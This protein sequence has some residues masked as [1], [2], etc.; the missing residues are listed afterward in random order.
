MESKPF[1]CSAQQRSAKRRK[2]TILCSTIVADPSFAAA[3]QPYPR[4]K[5]GLLITCPTQL[6]SAQ[7]FFSANLNGGPATHCLTVPP[8][9]SR[10]TTQ[11]ING[12]VC[13]DFGLCAT[14][15]NPSTRQAIT[16]PLVCSKTSKAASSTYYC[17]NSLGF[18]PVSKQYK[19]LNSWRNY[20]TGKTEY[21]VFSLGTQ[22]WRL[23]P[24]GPPY[25]PRRESICV[26]GIIYFRTLAD[27]VAFDVQNE[28]FRVIQLPSDAP[29]DVNT[30]CL[31]QLA[32]RLAIVNFQLDSQ[33]QLSL[34]ILEDYW[35]EIWIL[36]HIV[37]PTYWRKKNQNYLVAGTIATGEILLAP[38]FLSNPFYVFYYDLERSSLR[39]VKI[40]GL[41]E[42]DSLDVSRNAVTVTGYEE[43]IL[44][45]G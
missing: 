12:I 29:N 22:S 35:N 9:Y 21:R 7:T 36:H 31:I 3:H 5:P 20:Q 11:S 38:C 15:C 16:L 18:D 30:S 43:N 34:W 13:M 44:S 42:Y 33:N 28:T 39:R 41:P 32:G 25:S 17:V 26:N 40:R 19:V 37:F 45:L 4:P 6:Q 8:R 27:M 10:Y 1:K 24:D 2:H 14:L 23:L